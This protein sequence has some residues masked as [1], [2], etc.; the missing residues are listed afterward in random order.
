MITKN[1]VMDKLGITK[2]G[3]KARFKDYDNSAIHVKVGDEVAMEVVRHTGE[4]DFV[5]GRYDEEKR[6]YRVAY[7]PNMK[8]GKIKEIAVVYANNTD[9]TNKG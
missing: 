6:V 2:L 9:A 1:I 3:K 5:I 4:T 7:D 8:A